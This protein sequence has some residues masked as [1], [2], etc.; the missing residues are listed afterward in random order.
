MSSDHWDISNLIA[1]Y[2][3]LLNLGRIDE[4]GA[5]FRYGRITSEGNP[6][7]YEGVEAVTAMYREAV[8]FGTKL[9]DTLLF[10]S[11]LQ[12]HVDGDA[13]TSKAYFLA[14]TE[15]GDGPGTVLAGRYHD[16]FRRVDGE[17]WFEHRHMF[18]DLV[19]DLSTHLRRP[20]EDY[21]Q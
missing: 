13:A 18:T 8:H 16:R 20:L 19:G 4:V 21:Q 9:P 11:N 7:T 1:R 17:W 10:T 15:T 12:I 5:L 6:T 14:V 2:A 3:E